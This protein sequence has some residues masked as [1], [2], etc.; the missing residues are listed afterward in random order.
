MKFPWTTVDEERPLLSSD[1]TTVTT[2]TVFH[3]VGPTSY[4][5]DSVAGPLVAIVE[6]DKDDD[7]ETIADATQVGAA[8]E[9]K[10]P[11][12]FLTRGHILLLVVAVLYGTLN[13]S[14]R[15][16]YA[17]DHPPSASALST[18]RGW[19]A[20]LCFVPFWIMRPQ[21]RQRTENDTTVMTEPYKP[22]AL[23]RTAWELAFWNFGAQ[24]LTNA[25]LVYIPS[26]ARAAFLTQLSVVLTPLLSAAMGTRVHSNIWGGACPLALLGLVLL[27]LG[28]HDDDDSDPDST[29]GG[30][31]M[32]LGDLLCL[33]GALSWST[34]LYRLSAVGDAFPEIPLQ[35]W[36]TTFL[37]M[38]YTAWC[39]VSWFC[40]TTP[41]YLPWSG[42]NDPHTAWMAW[43]LL[44][45]S[46]A[47]PGTLADVLQ[48]KGQAT[49][50]ATVANIVLSL[51]P[52]FTAILGRFLL[53]E[54]TNG[55]EK[56]GGACLLAAA[57]LATRE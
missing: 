38:L 27:S 40:T 49:V 13:V 44:A 25:G 47:G 52:V 16:V 28:N 34:Y 7:E 31:G 17:M 1:E 8:I 14:L 56:L 2:T 30:L 11:F 9:H 21:H 22:A 23:Y 15:G 3:A 39:A 57:L 42:W 4:Q 29:A 43:L 46:A 55:W 26:S 45:Y 41:G 33:G 5:T 51:E 36:K 50:S 6:N 12:S 48:Q 20:A 35:A 19:L 32:G 18:V 53:G 24:G 37:A 54:E 10:S